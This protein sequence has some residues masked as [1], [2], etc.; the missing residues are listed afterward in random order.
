MRFLLPSPDF[1]TRGLVVMKFP[2]PED[3]EFGF[4]TKVNKKMQRRTLKQARAEQELK[5]RER[6]A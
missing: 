3:V 4:S 1:F 2:R 5:K 6:V